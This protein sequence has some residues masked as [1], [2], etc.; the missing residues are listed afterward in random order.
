MGQLSNT[1]G[2]LNSSKKEWNFK[3]FSE[4][5]RKSLLNQDL[6]INNYIKKSLN[7]EHI[8]HSK[9]IIIR[10]KEYLSI[11]LNT[12]KEGKLAIEKNNLATKIKKSLEIYTNLKVALNI[13]ESNRLDSTMV[14][15]SIGQKILNRSSVTMAFNTV[16]NL[17][18]KDN[19]VLGVRLQCSGRPGGQDMSSTQWIKHGSIPLHSYNV[20]IDYANESILTKYGLSG[21]KVWI[22][23]STK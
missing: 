1:T 16:L 21:I 14:C 6:N 20:S 4:R 8:I 23:Y 3:Y 13:T 15:Q 17:L 9:I 12:N 22:R 2:L 7:S 10:H 18:K 19:R 5:E 11:F